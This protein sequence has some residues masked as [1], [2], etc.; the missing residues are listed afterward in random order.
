L[1]A[2]KIFIGTGFFI[3]GLLKSFWSTDGRGAGTSIDF[4]DTEEEDLDLDLDLDL[5]RLDFDFFDF[6]GFP[7]LRLEDFEGGC[8]DPV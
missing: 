1:Q 3:A 4:T 6:F 2:I 5:E 8:D 7:D